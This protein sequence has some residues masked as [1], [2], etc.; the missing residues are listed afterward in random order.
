MRPDGVAV[1]LQRPPSSPTDFKS[2]MV[3]YHNVARALH[4]RVVKWNG[5]MSARSGP[6]N[7]RTRM[8]ARA[9]S[10]TATA[11]LLIRTGFQS[12]ERAP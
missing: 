2:A 5:T 8:L 9:A 7:A 6:R 10:N 3:Y 12:T 1:V 11:A 4:A